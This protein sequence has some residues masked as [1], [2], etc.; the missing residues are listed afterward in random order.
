VAIEMQT[1]TPRRLGG[2]ALALALVA[3]LVYA[4]AAAAGS[5]GGAGRTGRQLAAHLAALDP[6]R[7]VGG[8]TVVGSS[9][10]E[11]LVGVPHRINFIIALGRNS[12][13]TSGDKADQVGVL[14]R[15]ATINGGPGRDL[16]HGGPGHDV[17]RGGGGNDL[18]IDT[19]GS[20]TIYTGAG[21]NEV[22]VAG[23]PGGPD[24]VL[25]QAGAADRIFASRGD[26]IASSCHGSRVLYRRPPHTTPDG[27]ELA[28][29]ANGCTDNPA[30]DCSYPAAAGSLPGLLWWQRTPERQC[31]ASHPYLQFLDTVPFGTNAPFGVE[32]KNLGN[33]GFFAPR[34]VGE[35]SYVL[36]AKVGE[37]TNWTFSEQRWEMWLHC[38][39]DRDHGWR[40]GAA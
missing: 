24:R 33:I 2:L 23:H 29:N 30:V 8:N 13:I 28:P 4:G 27:S 10:G 38:T 17:I 36:G 14:G 12:T 15:N 25:C 6:G 22:D 16:I 1:G 21:R 34:L 18:I 20:A 9:N 31:P 3:A 11:F 19:K 26:Q 37:V 40:H 32:M 7:P 39:S 35:R 5:L